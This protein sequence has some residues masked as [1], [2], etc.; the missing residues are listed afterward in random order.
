[1]NTPQGK[2]IVVVLCVAAVMAVVLG[3]RWA[4]NI[5]SGPDVARLANEV[6]STRTDLPVL[7][8]EQAAAGAVSRGA[9]STAPSNMRTR[10][11][12]GSN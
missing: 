8:K 11:G 12:M 6:K 5:N 3:W 9:E 4:T 1:M 2:L 10:K 7:T